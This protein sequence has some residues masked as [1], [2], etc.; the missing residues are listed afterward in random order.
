MYAADDGAPLYGTKDLSWS[1]EATFFSLEE[2]HEAIM[3]RQC[4]W[5]KGRT[6]LGH[7]MA[8]KEIECVCRCFCKC[9]C[10]AC[11]YFFF[12]A[13]QRSQSYFAHVFVMSSHFIFQTKG[14][15]ASCSSFS[16]SCLT[17]LHFSF[18]SLFTLTSSFFPLSSLLLFPLLFITLP[19][20]FFVHHTRHSHI[21][22]VPFSHSLSPSTTLQ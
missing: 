3:D 1:E 14:G 20:F 4:H 10:G 17:S 18:L 11:L 6:F 13:N 5:E 7:T 8:H 16:T 22:T 9:P 12:V 19:F 21:H 2:E 15:F